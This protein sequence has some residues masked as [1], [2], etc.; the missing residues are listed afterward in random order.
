MIITQS[1]FD[2]SGSFEPPL[3]APEQGEFGNLSNSFNTCVTSL[4]A[5][6]RKGERLGARNGT[7][8]HLES[9]LRE[10]GDVRRAHEVRVCC[11]KFGVKTCGTHVLRYMPTSRCGHLACPDCAQWRQRRAEK[12]ILPRLRQYANS[13]PHLRVGFVTLT[14]KSSFE[15][16]RKIYGDLNADFA[17]LRRRVRW[18]RYVAAGVKVFDTTFSY[19]HGWHVHIHAIVFLRDFYPQDQLAVDWCSVTGG[20]GVVVDIRAVTE[21]ESGLREL[22]KYMVKPAD[23]VKLDAARIK[24]FD[25]MRG[26]RTLDAF[27]ELYGLKLDEDDDLGAEDESDEF[28]EGSPCPHCS[29]PIFSAFMDRETLEGMLRGEKVYRGSVSSVH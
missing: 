2:A 22:I 4:H 11:S 18:N 24:E 17:R 16:M 26:R 13:N 20:A 21:L 6:R 19:D 27:G 10:A 25:D 3:T 23:V 29:E 1:P 28:A 5:A 8:R 12:R 9:M 14:K 7:K 15:N